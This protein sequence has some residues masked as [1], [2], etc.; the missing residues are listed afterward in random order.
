M[1]LSWECRPRGSAIRV[2]ATLRALDLRENGF[3]TYTES[4][5][6]QTAGG[7]VILE[8]EGAR[9]GASMPHSPGANSPL[10]IVADG[11]SRS[12]SGL[13][14]GG[15]GV[16][17]AAAAAPSAPLDPGYPAYQPSLCEQAR[18]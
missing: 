6:L 4:A 3:D 14:L 7:R 11:L 13:Q 18:P 2:N 8:E 10:R 1:G 5:L 15:S 16:L 9:V 17:G 12:A